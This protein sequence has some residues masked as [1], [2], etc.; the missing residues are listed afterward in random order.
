MKSEFKK[1]FIKLF[2][3]TEKEFDE[4]YSAEAFRGIRINPLKSDIERVS[5]NFGFP[6]EKSSFYEHSYYLPKGFSGVGNLALHH[7]GGFYSQEPSASSVLSVVEVKPGDKVLDLCAAPGGKSTGIGSMLKGSGL[8]WS[9]EFVRKRAAA[10]VSNIERI[11]IKNGVVSSLDTNYLCGSLE[12]FFDK[13]VVDAPCSGEGMWRHNPLVEEQWSGDLV[14]Q[15]ADLQRQI[16]SA[17]AKAV[18]PGGRLIYSTC[19]FS[20]EENE[21]N[22]KWFLENFTEF[23]LLKIPF[24]FGM[25]GISGD[26]N[27]DGS[28]K[29]IIP[30]LGGE[31]HFLA[32]FER[33]NGDFWAEPE[34]ISEN[35][36]KENKK[37]TLD[38]LKENFEDFNPGILFEKNNTVYSVAENTPFIKGDVLRF[39]LPIGEVRKNRIEPS[40][41]IFTAAGITP[42]R[43]FNLSLEDQKVEEFLK[44]YEIVSDINQKGYVQILVENAPLGFGKQSGDRITNK[45]PKGLRKV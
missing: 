20:V 9:N 28:V 29:R 3:V 4:I 7:A 19:T 21:D 31:G 38:F 26:K 6:L 24:D 37:I 43:K 18:A 5:K 17:G 40:H 13:V 34:Y 14:L 42:R 39:G 27:I 35:I 2:G 1:K 44:G 15:C 32:V 12:G 22:V 23:K 10:L 11:G 33:Q 41:A 16:L 36:S 30:T 25:G 45:Y 8:L